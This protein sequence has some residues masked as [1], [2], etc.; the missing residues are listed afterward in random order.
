ML[1]VWS[2]I[3]TFSEPRLDEVPNDIMLQARL[4]DCG[5]ILPEGDQLG[6]FE[7]RNQY[8]DR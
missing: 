1:G 4:K 5:F 8:D 2:C 6:L 7:E 3:A